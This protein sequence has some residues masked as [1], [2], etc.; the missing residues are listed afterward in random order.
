MGPFTWGLPGSNITDAQRWTGSP[1]LTLL[2]TLM[3][4]CSLEGV[5]SLQF[6]E[7]LIPFCE[8]SLVE[9]MVNLRCLLLPS[10]GLTS[11]PSG[12]LIPL[13]IVFCRD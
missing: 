13:F 12:K 3:C 8:A 11:L 9:R 5:R 10:C 6:T 4:E 2:T 7:G 1:Q